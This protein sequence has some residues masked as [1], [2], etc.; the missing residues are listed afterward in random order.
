M[1]RRKHGDNPLQWR[2]VGGRGLYRVT[3]MRALL[4][5]DAE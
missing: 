5:G 2:R 1:T 3:S 4:T